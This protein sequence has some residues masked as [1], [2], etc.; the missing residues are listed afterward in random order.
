MS[1]ESGEGKAKAKQAKWPGQQKKKKF[2]KLPVTNKE[3]E[4][5]GFVK[6]IV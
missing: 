3:F 1:D 5:L 4:D 2:K 6:V